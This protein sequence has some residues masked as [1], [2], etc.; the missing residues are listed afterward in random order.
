MSAFQT[1][2]LAW[3]NCD[4]MELSER[5]ELEPVYAVRLE[6][7][8]ALMLGMHVKAITAANSGLSTRNN[9][10]MYV[11]LAHPQPCSQL[12]VNFT[13]NSDVQ[14]KHTKLADRDD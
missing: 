8:Q 2:Y 5:G 4:L 13:Q 7:Y 9:H 10:V 1:E 3:I 11:E 6:T 14:N 12:S